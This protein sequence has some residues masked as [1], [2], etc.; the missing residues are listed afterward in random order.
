MV[1]A[2]DIFVNNQLFFCLYV[3]D[4]QT[5]KPTELDKGKLNMNTISLAYH[6]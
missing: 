3:Q 6:S 4:H 5:E 2:F 1:L